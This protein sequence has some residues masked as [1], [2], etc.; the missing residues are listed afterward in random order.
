MFLSKRNGIYYLWYSD[1]S[2]RK[3]KISTHTSHKPEA[4]QFLRDFH[5]KGHNSRIT[6][7][8]LFGEL[9]KAKSGEYAEG[10]LGIYQ[11]SFRH[12]QRLFGDIRIRLLSPYHFDRYKAERLK[13][14]SATTVNIELRALKAA[15]GSAAKWKMVDT[16]PFSRLELARSA[17]QAPVYFTRTDFKLLLESIKE[18]WLRDVILFALLSGARRGEICNLRWSDV[19]LDNRLVHIQSSAS[20][21]TKMGKRRTIPIND[22]AYHLLM[23]RRYIS[24]GGYVFSNNNH[25]LRASWVT[26]RLKR[27]V[28]KLGLNDRL[29]FHSLRHSTGSWLAQSGISIYQISRLLGHSTVRTTEMFYAHLE[30][31]ALREAVGSLSLGA[32]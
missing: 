4:I 28:R 25:K 22:L 2:G 19:D 8:A 13:V 5:P 7:S 6:L 26:H 18:A 21:R 10:T 1:E 30:P 14:V 24:E 31:G 9:I 16:N 27:Y 11:K 32:I 20:F 17:E 29:H 23:N 15:L 12:L 3:Q